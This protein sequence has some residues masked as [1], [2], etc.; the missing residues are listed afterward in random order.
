MRVAGIDGTKRGWVAVV[1]ESDRVEAFG[2]RTIAEAIDRLV[3]AKAVAIDMPIG[4]A[5][6]AEAGG[7][8]C[9]K[10]A[11][12]I[13]GRGRTSSVFSSPCRA[14]L[15]AADYPAA[16]AANRES[17]PHRRGLSKQSHA[18]FTKMREIDAVMHPSLQDRLFEVHPEVSF[19]ELARLNGQTIEGSKKSFLGASQRAKL[20]GDAGILITPIL[21]EAKALGAST[22][23]IIDAAVA[24][25]TAKRFVSGVAGRIPELPDTDAKGLRM[26]IWF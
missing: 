20:L 3:D 12:S 2:V 8:L 7:R 15:E 10:A 6:A 17:S 26:E 5:T 11:R 24:A 21:G 14:A 19:T 1:L 22:D 18:L 4:F 25:W 23:D 9:E 16:S 13:L